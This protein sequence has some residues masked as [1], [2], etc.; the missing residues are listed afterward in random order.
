MYFFPPKACVT[1]ARQE[2]TPED[3]S[4]DLGSTVPNYADVEK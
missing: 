3:I 4:C 1:Q 2:V